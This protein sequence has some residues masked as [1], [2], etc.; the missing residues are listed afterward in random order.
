MAGVVINEFLA[1]NTAGI[2]DQDGD[3]NDWIELKNTD[4]APVDITGWHLTDESGN[5]AK[6]T[7]PATV[8]AP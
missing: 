8:L 3:R 4:P 5:L 6:W 2:V 7:L 1:S